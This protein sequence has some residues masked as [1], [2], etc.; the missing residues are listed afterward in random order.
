MLLR[1]IEEYLDVF[2][3]ERSNLE[4]L[5]KQVTAAEAVDDRQNFNGH[6]TASGIILSPDKGRVLLI[7]HKAY[8]VW[9][10]PG[11]HVDRNESPFDAAK[12]ETIEET[13]AE[14][15]KSIPLLDTN[16]SLPFD[17]DSHAVP[18]RPEKNEPAHWHHDF[19]YIFIAKSTDV[20][21][22]IAEV[23]DLDWF[24]FEAPETERIKHVIEKLKQRKII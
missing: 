5:I 23:V 12:R 7:H 22:Q 9:Q 16:P 1:L 4:R 11:G 21:R 24:D 8:D 19:R 14:I 13:G 18:A 6:I 15:E 10:Q 20:Q 17:I 2:P 3:G